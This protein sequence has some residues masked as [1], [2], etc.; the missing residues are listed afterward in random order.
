[1]SILIQRPG[2]L[3]TVQDLGRHGHRRFGVNPGGVMDRAAARLINILLRNYEAEAVFELHFPAPQI[4]FEKECVIAIG[5]ADFDPKLNELPIPSWTAVTCPANSVLRFAGKGSG[6]RAYL[7]IKGGLLLEPWL[8]S[9]AT[10][11]AAKTGGLSGRRL[12]AGDRMHFRTSIQTWSSGSAISPWLIPNYE[13][14]PKVRVLPGAEYD[15]LSKDGRDQ[16]LN[17]SFTISST[18]DRMGFRLMS[19]P[20][21]LTN[22]GEMVSSP[23]SFGTIQS[24]PDDQL[25]ILM[26]DHQTT[27][28]YP[29]IGHIISHDLPLVAQLGPGDKLSFVL[30]EQQEAEKLELEFARSLKFLRV[31]SRFESA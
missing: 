20:V 30:V 10:N 22:R 19:D 28:G 5:G 13:T 7:A 12:E 8:G 2:I 15:K 23:V 25:I 26:A 17:G 14:A 21:V 24:L 18:S 31:G 11:L 3:S 4:L 16:L 9:L 29:R 1:M 27:G 6:N